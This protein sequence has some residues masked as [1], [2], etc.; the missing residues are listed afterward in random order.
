MTRWLYRLW[1]VLFSMGWILPFTFSL[2]A[3]YDFVWRVVWPMAAWRDGSHLNPYHPFE[4][5]AALLYVSAVWLALVI[6]FWV[7]KATR[8]RS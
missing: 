7:F 2:A 6:V 5:S 8:P 1:L 3:A 4:W